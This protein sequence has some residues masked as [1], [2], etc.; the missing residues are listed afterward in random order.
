MNRTPLIAGNWKMYKTPAEAARTARELIQRVTDVTDVEVM[1]APPFTALA[2]V[3]DQ[4]LG[5]KVLKLF[6]ATTGAYSACTATTINIAAS[7]PNV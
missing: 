3:A 5:S 1:I 2:A 7:P 6:S 4:V